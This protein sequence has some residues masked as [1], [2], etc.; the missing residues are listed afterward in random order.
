MKQ[1]SNEAELLALFLQDL[2]AI[3]C[4]AHGQPTVAAVLCD[5]FI[6]IYRHPVLAKYP[7]FAALVDDILFLHTDRVRD[8]LDWQ[9]V[10]NKAAKMVEEM[11]CNTPELRGMMRY[12]R[13]RNN[14]CHVV[15]TGYSFRRSRHM[16]NVGRKRSTDLARFYLQI[17]KRLPS[18]GQGPVITQGETAIALLERALEAGRHPVLKQDVPSVFP[19]KALL[20][21][22]AM[23]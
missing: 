3:D 13:G 21:R 6:S 15:S 14:L 2:M 18:S 5:W 4:F 22:G 7:C 8:S 20:T 1:S 9:L 19:L 11:A 16:K 10:R 12:P 23:V 17:K